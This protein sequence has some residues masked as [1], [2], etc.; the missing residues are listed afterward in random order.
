MKVMKNL[1]ITCETLENHETQ[2][3]SIDNNENHKNHGST[4]KNNENHKIVECHLKII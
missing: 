3:K 2:N 1:G 4:K